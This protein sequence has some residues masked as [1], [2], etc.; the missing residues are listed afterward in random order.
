MADQSEETNNDF[1]L[2]TS[3]GVEKIE[4]HQRDNISVGVPFSL[5]QN[6]PAEASIDVES[7]QPGKETVAAS[8]YDKGEYFGINA[9]YLPRQQG[10]TMICT[11]LLEIILSNP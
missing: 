1:E 8:T 4:L 10:V 11:Y 7:D 2:K 3:V 9:S 6:H 5:G